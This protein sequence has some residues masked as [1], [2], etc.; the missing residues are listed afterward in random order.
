MVTTDAPS[1]PGRVT[2]RLLTVVWGDGR[3]RDDPAEARRRR[4]AVSG[5]LAITAVAGLASALHALTIPPF[6][7]PDEAP[8]VNYALSLAA[9][10]IP[11]V[12]ERPDPPPMPLMRDLSVWVANHPPLWYVFLA[13]PLMAGL[14]FD[15]PIV[16]L[17]AARLGIVA[18]VAVGNLMVGW[19]AVLL[20]PRRP[21]A[22]VAA[23]GVAA[24]VPAGLHS[25]GMVYTDGPTFAL[26]AA[27]LVAGLVVLRRGV[28]LPRLILLTLLGMAAGYA[29]IV[30]LAAALGCIACVV[31][32]ELMHGRGTALLRGVRGVFF[33]TASAAVVL[34]SSA[35]FYVLFNWER[36]GSFTATSALMELHGRSPRGTTLA[37]RLV[38]DD[39]LRLLNSQYWNRVEADALNDPYLPEL[40]LVAGR[41]LLGLALLAALLVGLWRVARG[42][43]RQPLP[44]AMCWAVAI[45]WFLVLYVAMA[46]FVQ[47]GGGPHL[48][49]LWP[50]VGSLAVVVVA[51]LSAPPRRWAAVGPILFVGYQ[52]VCAAVILTGLVIRE[53]VLYEPQRVAMRALAADEPQ[54]ALAVM[55]VAAVV[56]LA[57]FVWWARVVV[58]LAGDDDRAHLQAPARGR[59]VTLPF[60]DRR[61]EV[62]PVDVALAT[63]AGTGGAWFAAKQVGLGVH[64]ATLA[65]AVAVAAVVVS[66]TAR[67]RVPPSAETGA[68]D[69]AAGSSGGRAAPADAT[70]RSEAHHL[71]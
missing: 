52:A 47:V 34:A 43:W 38:S 53:E 9:A 68:P 8:H 42:A 61:V 26:I 32:A 58:V 28:T 31:A 35:W 6:S 65:G 71:Q 12:H 54:M 48:R 15:A 21:G 13:P 64:L 10:E 17:F 56:A 60:G 19:F 57:G 5:V 70:A 39:Y 14:A 3:H 11:W 67:R 24:L 29:R 59:A 4:L 22:A 40:M 69:T 7:P 55:V 16:G 45:G 27:L 30:G 62:R 46:R 23:T 66:A 33:A 41:W 51:G 49:Y 50:A 37:E 1:L 20:L 25:A 18:A 44:L 2:D 63:V 36:Y